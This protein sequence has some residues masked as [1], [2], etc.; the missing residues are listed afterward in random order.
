MRGHSMD[1][2]DAL[3]TSWVLLVR[4]IGEDP[5]RAQD[6]GT[7]VIQR[8]LTGPGLVKELEDIIA[9]ADATRSAV[10]QVQP[11]EPV[12]KKRRPKREKAA[13]DPIEVVG[14]GEAALRAKLTALTRSQL[15]DIISEYAIDPSH[16]VSRRRTLAPIVDFIVEV[17]LTRARKGDGFKT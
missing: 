3:P 6:V 11:A 4:W 8:I 10:A 17:S 16:I 13:F 14:D 7:R 12:A 9:G 5:A 2:Y 15:I 1:L